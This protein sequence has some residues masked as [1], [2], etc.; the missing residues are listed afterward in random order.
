V[1]YK[2]NVEYIRD[3]FLKRGVPVECKTDDEMNIDFNSTNLKIIDF[4]CAKG[5]QFSNVFIPLCEYHEEYEKS[6]LYVAATRPLDNLYLMYDSRLSWFLAPPTSPI[7][8]GNNQT[9]NVP[10]K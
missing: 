4:H 1:Y 7:Y 6:A 9:T 3:Y 2:K 8:A 5:L 10:F